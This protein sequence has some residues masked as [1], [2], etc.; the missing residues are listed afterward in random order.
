MALS[1]DERVDR[2]R[3][4]R[5]IAL[6]RTFGLLA[7]TGFLLAV[8]GRFGVFEGGPYVARLSVAGLIVDDPARD[9][10][11]SHL[12]TDPRVRGLIL[13][14][15]SPGGTVVGGEALYLSLRQFAEQKPV[16]AV[17]GTLAT[18]A[19]YMAALAADHIVAREGTVT[20]SIGVIVQTVE[21]SALLKDLGVEA[22][23]IKSGPLKDATSPFEPLTK[24]ARA[25]T[26]AVVDDMYD[27]FVSL[28]AA[29]RGLAPEETRA[30]ADGRVFTGRQAAAAKLVDAVGGEAEARAWLE[31]NGVVPGLPVREVA[32]EHDE[33]WLALLAGSAK[34]ALYP[35]SLVLDGG[36]SVWHPG[37]K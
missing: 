2:R 11:L 8:L 32:P 14:I 35:E 16:A 15:D 18:S 19:A 1:A 12:A 13:R 3:L 24:E 33:E 30:L 7:F 27:M 22:E 17:M 28:V 9:E 10:L 29:R 5:R 34:K 23:A 6:W 26:Q 21:V 36:V 20:G 31:Q 4:K 25:A 37:F